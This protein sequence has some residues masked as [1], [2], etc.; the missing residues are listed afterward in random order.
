MES[1]TKYPLLTESKVHVNNG[2]EDD[3]GIGLRISSDQHEQSV[4]L[5]KGGWKSAIYVI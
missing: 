5:I 4:Q 1:S 2:D 3:Q